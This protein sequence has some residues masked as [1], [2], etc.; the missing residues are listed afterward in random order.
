MLS[1]VKGLDIFY[2]IK[3]ELMNRSDTFIHWKQGRQGKARNREFVAVSLTT[4]IEDLS[5]STKQLLDLL[6]YT[7]LKNKR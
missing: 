4:A 1:A 5:T 3:Y 6:A 2:D 7:Y